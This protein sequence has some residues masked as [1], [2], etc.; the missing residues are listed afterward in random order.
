VASPGTTVTAAQFASRLRG[1]ADRPALGADV[2]E[3]A[4]DRRFNRSRYDGRR[5]IDAFADG[6]REQVN[7]AEISDGALAV[8]RSLGP[9]GAAVWIRPNRV[10]AP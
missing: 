4:V 5:I 2:L 9:R 7:L 1:Q 8:T 6:L 10:R 3:A